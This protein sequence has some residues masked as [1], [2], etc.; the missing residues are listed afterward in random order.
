MVKATSAST[1]TQTNFLSEDAL[2]NRRAIDYYL[3]ASAPDAPNFVLNDNLSFEDALAHAADLLHCAVETAHGSAEAMNAQQRAVMHLV[4]MAKEVVG[5][6]L[7]CVQP[8]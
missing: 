8:R 6:A 7:E 2:L 3:K 4:G 1:D 5:R